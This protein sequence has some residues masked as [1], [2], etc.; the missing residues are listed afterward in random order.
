MGKGKDYENFLVNKLY[1]ETSPGIYATRCAYSGSGALP[2]PDM[3]VVDNNWNQTHGLEVKKRD[4]RRNKNG[5]YTPVDVLEPDDMEQL[6]WVNKNGVRTWVAV[7]FTNR[8][9][10]VFEY[11]N[12]WI[13]NI[14]ECFEPRMVNGKLK[15]RK[16]QTDE[17]PSAKAGRSDLEVLSEKL[18]LKTAPVVTKK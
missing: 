13:D 8:E 18:D 5:T 14:P 15:L 12:G 3:L 10:L 4:P 1:W 2:Q 16:P 7:K 6:K 9:L 11:D 17:W